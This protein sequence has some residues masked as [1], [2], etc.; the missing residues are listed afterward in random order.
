MYAIKAI[1]CNKLMLPAYFVLGEVYSIRKDEV[2]TDEAFYK[3]LENDLDCENLR[4]EWGKACV[5]LFDFKKAKQ[6]FTVAI[7][8]NPES[9]NAKI[10]LALVSAY[11]ND[12]ERLSEVKEKNQANVYIQ[13]ATGLE[14]FS[15]GKYEEA[16]E[17]FKKALKTDPLQSYNLLNLARVYKY[18]NRDDKVREFYEKFVTENPKYKDGLTEYAK[19]L[20]DVSDFADAKRKLQKAENID[21]KDF[22]ILNLIFYS[23]YRLVKE[24][25]SEYNVKEAISVAEK[26]YTLGGD[27]K[28]EPEKQDLEVML[29]EIQG[30]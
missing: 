3:A 6:N 15:Q 7:E 20:T 21:N 27:F 24:N 30:K 29:N 1:E 18:L 19:W 25:I 8:K 22:E 4:I 17:M 10:G 14:M 26:I 16:A 23:M 12:F 28:Y 13:E 2:L 5:R 11:E 9:E